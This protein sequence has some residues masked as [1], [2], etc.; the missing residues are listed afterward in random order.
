M[1]VVAEL[2]ASIA[3]LWLPQAL[4]VCKHKSSKFAYTADSSTG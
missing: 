4:I 3:A 2:A 1:T